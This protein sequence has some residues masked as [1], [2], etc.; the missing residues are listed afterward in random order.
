MEFHRDAFI[1]ER[2]TSGERRQ[3]AILLRHRQGEA[4]KIDDDD[5]VG[6]VGVHFRPPRRRRSQNRMRAHDVSLASGRRRR[7]I[8]MRLHLQGSLAEECVGRPSRKVSHRPRVSDV[9]G[10]DSA[11]RKRS[12]VISLFVNSDAMEVV[13]REHGMQYP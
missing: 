2:F 3:T 8:G 1:V 10:S 11:T 12:I 4:S 5:V 9:D 7:R 6:R 13:R